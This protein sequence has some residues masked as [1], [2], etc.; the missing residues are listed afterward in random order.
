MIRAETPPRQAGEHRPA[1]VVHDAV[2]TDPAAGRPWFAMEHLVTVGE[3]TRAGF[4]Y[5][6]TLFEWQGRCRELFGF[7]QLPLYMTALGVDRALLTVSASCEFLGEIFEGERVS[8]RLSVPWV[9]L[10]YMKGEF[11]FYRVTDHDAELVARGEQ[12]WANML[13]SGPLPSPVFSPAPW[14]QDVLDLCGRMQT[15]VSRALIR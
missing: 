3:T 13:R 12:M 4:V 9:R 2:P 11:A 15:D 8:V 5:Y 7:R 14:P 1:M 6:A 10:H